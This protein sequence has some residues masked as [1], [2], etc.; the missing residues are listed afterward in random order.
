MSLYKLNHVSH[1][2]PSGFNIYIENLI[3]HKGDILGFSGANGS[4]KST[5]MKLLAF[6]DFPHTGD[7]YY[8]SEKVSRKN[9]TSL[10]K[11]VSMLFQNTTLLHRSVYENIIYGLKVRN[12]K[13]DTEQCIDEILPALGIPSSY[14]KRNWYELSGGE[15]KRIALAS[16]LIM[17]P[18]VILLDEPTA[19][20]DSESAFQIFNAIKTYN[21]SFNTTFI[22]SSHDTNW[23]SKTTDKV[24]AM[25]NGRTKGVVVDNQLG[26]VIEKLENNLVKIRLA[27]DQ[28]ILAYPPKDTFSTEPHIAPEDILISKSNIEDIS[29]QNS[30]FGKV[31]KLELVS[32]NK[33]M[34]SC[35]IENTTFYAYITENGAEKL[36]LH[37]GAHIH[38][39]FKINSVK[40]M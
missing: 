16:R 29:A 36:G 4:G 15:A 34:V 26:T 33:I 19:E 18:E 17:N 39:I 1:T 22:I 3:I 40:W 37:P 10:R 5:L 28:Y 32:E 13:V 25:E 6:L 14:L 21:K 31:T 7:L 9:L 35:V 38:L 11:H 20:I 2:Y 8:D 30:L 23:L 12:M 27:E 24:I